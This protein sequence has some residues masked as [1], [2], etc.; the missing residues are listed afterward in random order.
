MQSPR[1]KRILL[2][3]SGESLMGDQQFG[4]S[5]SILKQYAKDVAKVY[6]LGVEIGIVIGGGNFIRG[7]Q[8]AFG[9]RGSSNLHARRGYG[10]QSEPGSSGLHPI[11][12]RGRSITSRLRQASRVGC[13]RCCS[14][15]PDGTDQSWNRFGDRRHRGQLP[16]YHRPAH[17]HS[18]AETRTRGSR[19]W[20][21]T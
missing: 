9:G 10:R 17:Y 3:L 15:G 12:R 13:P 4:L 6:Q 11:G 18:G 8:A 20:P 16:D 14:C 2:K 5:S 19:W 7:E 1:Y 21:G